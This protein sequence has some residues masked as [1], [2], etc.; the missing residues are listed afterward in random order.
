MNESKKINWLKM[1]D[2]TVDFVTGLAVGLLI[3]HFC[4]T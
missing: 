3:Y 2:E 4:M 1:V